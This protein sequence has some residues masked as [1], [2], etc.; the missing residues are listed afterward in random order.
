ML[1]H[2]DIVIATSTKLI[3]KLVEKAIIFIT[4]MMVSILPCNIC[5]AGSMSCQ[6]LHELLFVCIMSSD[7]VT[8]PQSG[9]VPLKKVAKKP[10][11]VLISDHFHLS[12]LHLVPAPLDI[13]RVF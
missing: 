12:Q 8:P 9:V 4:L 1:L 6:M 5:D 7:T 3:S 13:W 10:H 11:V 2:V